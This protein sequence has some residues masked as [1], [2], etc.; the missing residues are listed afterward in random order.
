[1]A[2]FALHGRV[3]LAWAL[4]HAAPPDVDVVA[5]LDDLPS[6]LTAGIRPWHPFWLAVTAE[7]WQ[8]VGHLEEARQLV[9]EAWAEIEAMGSSFSVAE[10]LRLRGELLAVLEPGRRAEAV[11][12]LHEAARRAEEQ[13]ASVYRDR[14]LASA[15]RLE[16]AGASEPTGG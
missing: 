16:H 11:A 10:V 12:D 7:A 1:M 15:A 4:A 13:G 14:A 6:A 8:R 3:V 9:D 2:D 5:L